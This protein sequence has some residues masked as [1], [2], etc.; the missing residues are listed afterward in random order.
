MLS[1][2]EQIFVVS[3]LWL[4]FRRLRFKKRTHKC[5]V[6]SRNASRATNGAYHCLVTH[7][8]F[9]DSQ[10]FFSYLRMSPTTFENLYRLVAPRI[11]HPW[12]DRSASVDRRPE[13]SP[14]ERIVVTIRYLATGN[15]QTC[16]AFEFHMGNSIVCAIIRETCDALWEALRTEYVKC[17]SS[18]DEWKTVGQ[19]F[20]NR[21][22]FPHCLGAI[23]GKHVLIQA[24]SNSGSSFF[25]Y[26]GT[27]SIVL[28]AVVDANYK[29]I[30]VD[31]GNYGRQSDG[32]TFSRSSLTTAMEKGT[33]S[34]PLPSLLLNDIEA[35]YVFV[36]DEA[37]PLK[38][39]LMRPYPGRNLPEDQAIFN[40]K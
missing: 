32:G 16:M 1:A 18:E 28:L 19:N 39:N 27:H 13:I 33:L 40:Y 4:L 17:P 6:K 7:L 38:K 26:K 10:G 37:F 36:G 9:F 34:L 3:L 23:D 14:Q 31:V 24:P 12:A 2:A 29:F 20:A 11:C 21:W 5:W 8:R 35:P 22:N 15:S 30:Y 25:N